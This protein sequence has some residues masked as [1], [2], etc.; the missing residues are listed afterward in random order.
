MTSIN[1]DA[2]ERLVSREIEVDV[3]SV[4]LRLHV[5]PSGIIREA[6]KTILKG[7]LAAKREDS[8]D[9]DLISTATVDALTDV[10]AGAADIEKELAGQIIAIAGGETGELATEL[11][12]LIGMDV[13]AMRTAQDEGEADPP[14]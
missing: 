11:M 12:K 6:R 10:L 1:Q 4:M 13:S 8:K 5:P 9:D 7:A 2:V 14:T 3:D